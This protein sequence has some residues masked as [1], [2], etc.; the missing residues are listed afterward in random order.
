MSQDSCVY[1]YTLTD[2]FFTAI[3]APEIQKGNLK[4]LLNVRK[5]IGVFL[6]SFHIEGTVVVPCDRCLDDMDVSVNMDNELKVKLGMEFSDEEELVVVPEEDGYIDVAWF[7][8]EF[9]ALSL[10][11]KHVH[12]P[13]ECNKSMMGA[14]SRHLLTS[15]DEEDD[16]ADDMD[17]EIYDEAE[18]PQQTDPRWDALKKILD[19]N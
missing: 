11:M 2:D 1:E 13:G 19:N 5:S 10:P 17:D 12:A 9:I 16:F 15:A 4:V 14:L 7:M 8:Y 6:L 18:I 3:D